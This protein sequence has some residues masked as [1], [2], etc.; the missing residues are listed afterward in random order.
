MTNVMWFRRDLRLAD[1]PALLAATADGPVVAVFV[2][3]DALRGPAGAPRLTFL[4]RCLRALDD[5]L[6]GRLVVR[7]GRPADVLLALARDVGARQVYAAT[8]YGPYGHARDEAVSARLATAK[9]SLELIGSPYAV[10]PG[11]TVKPDGSPYRVF[12]PFYRAWSELGW[13]LPASLPTRADVVANVRSEGVPADPRL[14][15]ALPP[16]GEAAA[17]ARLDEFVEQSVTDYAR[18]RSSLGEDATSKLSPYLKY[19]CVHPRQVLARLAVSGGD[20]KFRTEI[21]WREFYADVLWHHPQ[22][23]REA[24]VAGTGAIRVDTGADADARFDAW[25]TGHTG[26]PIVDAAMRH[27]LAEAWLP[28]RARM[29]A[30]SFLIKDLHLDWRRGA[31]HFMAYLVDGDLASN[32]HGWQWVAGTGTDAAPYHRVFNPVLQGEKFDPTGAYVRRWVP[33]LSDVADDAIHRPWTLG[34]VAPADY[35]PP[36]VDHAVERRIALHRFAAT[37]S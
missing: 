2:L 18:A 30:A 5:S 3:D 9:V 31:R 10:E 12:T 24:L 16:A 29:V 28:N 27:L 22:S 13:P 26:Y 1:N 6:D 35:P 23:V 15:A 14:D 20:E 21:A 34:L 32:T 11:R 33:E 36:I 7:A 19:G 4:Y 37:K 25:A 17:L 8:D